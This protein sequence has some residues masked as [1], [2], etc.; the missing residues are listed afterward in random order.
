MKRSCSINSFLF[1]FLGAILFISLG[2]YYQQITGREGMTG[3]E[4]RKGGGDWTPPSADK[5]GICE[6]KNEKENIFANN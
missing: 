3:S 5:E 4:C 2:Y 1:F 6:K